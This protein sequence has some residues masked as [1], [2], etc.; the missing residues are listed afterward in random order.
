MKNLATGKLT[1]ASAKSNGDQVT[2]LGGANDALGASERPLAISADGRFVAFEAYAALV[3]NDTND[4]RDV[5]LH[6]GQTGKTTRVSV[7]NG[8]PNG[9]QVT[10]GAGG[11]QLPAIS[12]DGRWVA[13]QTIA[14]VTGKDSGGDF[15]VFERGPLH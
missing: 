6:D 8:G 15:D 3:G 14:K 11:Q 12:A 10:S 2:A 7:K 1:L 9:G 4:E 5:Y 13:F